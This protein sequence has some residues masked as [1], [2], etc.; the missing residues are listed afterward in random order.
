MAD[1]RAVPPGSA[2]GPRALGSSVSAPAHNHAA[3]R[4]AA[5]VLA[6][7]DLPCDPRTLE[8]WG[9]AVGAGR[10]TLRCWCRAAHLAPKASLDFARLLRAVVRSQDGGW[11]P[12]N[13]LDV[14]DSRTLKGLLR[15]GGLADR[16]GADDRPPTCEE[17]LSRQRLVSQEAALR[18]LAEGLEA[19]EKRRRRSN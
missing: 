7:L 13:I 1:S 17:F 14:V 3:E 19:C 16:R 18:A 5:I 15:R 11:D 4:W 9:R 12:Y 2:R 6:V 10:G 8:S